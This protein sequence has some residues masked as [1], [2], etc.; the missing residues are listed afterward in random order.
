MGN[1]IRYESNTAR[2]GRVITYRVVIDGV[3]FTAERM[4]GVHNDYRVS[5]TVGVCGHSGRSD[6]ATVPSRAPGG[7]IEDRFAALAAELRK[8]PA[9]FIHP[10]HADP[11]TR[12]AAM[13]TDQKACDRFR[14][15]PARDHSQANDAD[16]SRA[17][18]AGTWA[19]NTGHPKDWTTV[20]R[21]RALIEPDEQH[22]P[23]ALQLIEAFNARWEANAEYARRRDAEREA[24]SA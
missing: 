19:F 8:D 1:V 18:T 24:V 9:N 20:Y 3:A 13:C 23:R 6:V 12:H 17:D 5:T 15:Y 4:V 21:M 11:T 10:K 2:F 7:K 14:E 16:L 22:T